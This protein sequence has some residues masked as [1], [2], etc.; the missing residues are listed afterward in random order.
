M[1][2]EREEEPVGYVYIRS[3]PAL[4]TVGFYRPDGTWEPESDHGSTEDAAR[5]V[6][7]LNGGCPDGE[8]LEQI[9]ANA[10][11]QR[12]QDAAAEVIAVEYVR[13]LEAVSAT[14]ADML[15]R[16]VKTSDGYRAR[17]GQ[18]QIGRWAELVAGRGKP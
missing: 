2:R 11:S 9:L 6:I 1:P 4:W 13:H 16:F 5:R 3:E 7:S 17:V 8:L 15:S 12:D 18:V 10:G 14:A